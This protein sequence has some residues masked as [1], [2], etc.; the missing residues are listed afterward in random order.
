[1]KNFL[2]GVSKSNKLNSINIGDYIQALASSQFF[3]KVD[4]FLDRDIDLKNYD[5]DVCKMIMNGW[6]MHNPEN[7]PPS[8]KIVPLY[9]SFHLTKEALENMLNDQ[10]IS[11]LKEHEPIGCRDHFTES[12]LL[13]R[14]I[15][16]YFSGC[17]TLTLGYSFA[18][19][20][21]NGKCCFVDP[22]FDS[23]FRY[24]F[25]LPN[26]FF[27]LLNRKVINKLSKSITLPYPRNFSEN[28][29]LKKLRVVDFYREYRKVF[30]EKLLINAEYITHESK[31][32]FAMSDKELLGLAQELVQKYAMSELVVTSRIHCAL[33]CLSV[34]TDVL[35]VDNVQQDKWSSCRLDGIKELFNVIKWKDGHLYKTFNFK[36]KISL[37]SKPKNGQQ[38]KPFADK[39]V[40]TIMDFMK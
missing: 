4:G 30:D 17:M 35:Y 25:V 31:Q 38:W 37:S 13:A 24:L 22:F 6:Y 34:G 33:P 9:V 16:A 23:R 2:L 27:Y 40:K 5:G 12:E 28:N 18:S 7:W 20:L 1:M 15:N 36:E 11:Y 19:K 29:L 14:G 26:L 32:W 39:L 21:K 3:P 10:G 8:A